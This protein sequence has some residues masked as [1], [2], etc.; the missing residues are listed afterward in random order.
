[1]QL[2]HSLNKAHQHEIAEESFPYSVAELLDYLL[3]HSETGGEADAILE[4]GPGRQVD[5]LL[6][7]DPAACA[8]LIIPFGVPELLDSLQAAEAW[9][10]AGKLAS[11]L[12]AAGL[13]RSS[14]RKNK[15]SSS[16]TG[17]SPTAPRR[18]HG[19][20]RTWT[21][22]PHALGRPAPRSPSS[23]RSHPKASSS[24]V[25]R[26]LAAWPEP[27]SEDS[28]ICAFSPSRRASA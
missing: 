18:R 17:K 8:E 7:R 16:P 3:D 10:Q 27:A 6:A 28:T 19:H 26:R 11:R 2:L 12:P 22:P 13:F 14:C 4:Y 1:M 20:G 21:Y 9:A 5:T 23:P 15:E 25:Q 24:A